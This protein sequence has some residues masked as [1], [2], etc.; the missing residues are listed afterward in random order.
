MNRNEPGTSQSA[1]ILNALVV[2]LPL[3]VAATKVLPGVP[4]IDVADLLGSAWSS[5]LAHTV[6]SLSLIRTIL[7]ARRSSAVCAWLLRPVVGRRIA[8]RL[9]AAP[10][11]GDLIVSACHELRARDGRP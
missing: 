1:R 6:A 9:C 7:G 8:E 2:A 5:A 4:A 11:V 10:P 3:L